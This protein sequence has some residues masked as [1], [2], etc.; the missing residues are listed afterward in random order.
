[1]DL[2]WKLILCT[3]K[4]NSRE[5]AQKYTLANSYYRKVEKVKDT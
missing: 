1:M 2:G 4:I 3:K 5:N